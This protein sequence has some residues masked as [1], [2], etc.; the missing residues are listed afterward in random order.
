MPDQHTL[1][2]AYAT[3]YTHTADKTES[4]LRQIYT[5]ARNSFIRRRFGYPDTEKRWWVRTLG[6]LMG[7]L[8]HRRIGMEAMVMWLTCKPGGRLLEIGC[9]NG[10]RL[11]LFQSLGWQ[12]SGLEPDSSAALLA[13]A[14]GLDVKALAL[15]P[16][17]LSHGA[18]DAIVMSHVI[19]HVADPQATIEECYRLLSPN[20][21]LVML[22]P[23]TESLGHRWFVRNWL[24]LDPPR[25]LNL[26]NRSNLPKL[27]SDVGFPAVRCV[28][29]PRD[30][31]WTL[32]A[33]LALQR[34][35]RYA[36]G[37]LPLG[38]KHLGLCFFYIEWVIL[39]Y[40]PGRGEEILVTARR[41]D[42]RSLCH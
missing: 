6:N 41:P 18:F 23:N 12:V 4:T 42:P 1:T 37:R 31:N 14:K 3:Y 34:Y 13:Q 5:N 25:H 39:L 21:T 20:G 7:L 32:G 22:T 27:C 35:D 30:A 38:F 2:D 16:G 40:H 10:D 29:T 28:T 26:F 19:E 15:T 17:V 36:I 9:G 24:H 11:A 33:S 8:P